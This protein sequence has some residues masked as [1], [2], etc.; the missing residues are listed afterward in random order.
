MPA[1]GNIDTLPKNW[2][3]LERAYPLFLEIRSEIIPTYHSA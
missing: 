3:N 2:R 1:V